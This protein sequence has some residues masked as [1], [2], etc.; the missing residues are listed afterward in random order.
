[1]RRI[2]FIGGAVL[3]AAM[4]IGMVPTASAQAP[5]PVPN[6]FL[7]GVP[8]EL[9]NPGGSAP[10]SNDWSCKPSAEHPNPVVLVH[11]TGGNRQTN[12]ATYAPLLANEGY[13]VF[14]LTYG[15][16]PEQPWP[17]SAIGGMQEISSS[18][19]QLSSFVD[20][21]LAAAGAEKVDLIGH[22]QGTVINGYYAKFLGGADKVDNVISVAPLWKGTLGNEQASIGRSMR[23]LGI[24]DAAQ[25]GFPICK[26]CLNMAAGSEFIDNL[27][28]GGVYMPGIRYTN[29]VTRYDELVLPYTNGLEPGPN[30]TNIVVQEGCE[31][32]IS[33]HLAIAASR[34][35]AMFALNALDSANP[36]QV[37]CDPVWPIVG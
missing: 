27:R 34:R 28:A 26:A 17:L 32:D 12:W 7:A 5:L 10:G 8:Q 25:A 14:A 19:A 4:L 16:F 30:A 1:M 33:D 23:D 22:S 18:A 3:A 11:G 6:G 15:N 2:G 20:Q 31:Q 36:R 13:C 35:S 29:I 24:S 21:V 9:G 37:P